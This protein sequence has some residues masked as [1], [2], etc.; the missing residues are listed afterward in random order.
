MPYATWMNAMT[1][2]ASVFTNVP[3]MKPLSRGQFN[4]A[5]LR[6][7]NRTTSAVWMAVLAA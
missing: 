7:K 4:L 1:S 2:I 3:A 6:I 5:S